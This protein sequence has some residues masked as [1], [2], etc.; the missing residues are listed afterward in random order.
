MKISPTDFGLG[1]ARYLVG[2]TE[3]DW[4]NIVEQLRFKRQLSIAVGA[5]N[6]LLDHP[7]HRAVAI[8]AFRRIGL[9]QFL[10]DA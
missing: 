2:A 8:A 6:V 1:V 5:M 7:E 3:E 10:G 4:P 9:W